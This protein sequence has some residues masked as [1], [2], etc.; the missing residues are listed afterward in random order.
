[1]KMQVDNVLEIAALGVI[2]TK[3]WVYSD[4]KYTSSKYDFA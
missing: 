3:V 2:H 4:T 1:M